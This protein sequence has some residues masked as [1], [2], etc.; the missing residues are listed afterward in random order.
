MLLGGGSLDALDL[1]GGREA[2]REGKLGQ[3]VDPSD[4]AGLK[5]AVLRAL[6]L[7]KGVPDGLDYFGLPAYRERISDLLTRLAG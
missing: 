6:D 7:P 5:A 4:R 3:V 2:V 1:D